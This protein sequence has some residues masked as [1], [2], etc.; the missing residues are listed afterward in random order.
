MCEF[1]EQCAKSR[2]SVALCLI[3]AVAGWLGCGGGAETSFVQRPTTPETPQPQP[4]TYTNPLLATIPSGGA[5]ESCADPSVLQAQDNNWYV[6]CTGDPLNDTD[7]NSTGGWIYHGIPIL[8][9][10][11]L[12]DWTYVGDVFATKPAWVAADGGLWAPLIRYSGGK[13]YL[14]YSASKTN[15]PGNGS[16]IGV[17]TSS[18]PAGPWTDAGA[19]VVEPGERAAIDPDVIED[20][21]EKYIYF[22]SFYGGIRVRKLS[23]DGLRSDASSEQ[24]IAISNR[25]EAANVVKRDGYYYLFA[26]ASDCCRGP[27]TG[28]SVFAGRSTSPQGPFLDRDGISLLAGRPGGTLALGMNGNRWV[29]PGHGA[30]FT[31]NARQDWMIYHAVDRNRPYFAGA[32][33]FTRRPLMLDPIDWVDGWPVVRGGN[34]ASDSSQAKPAAQAGETN[35]YS[36]TMRVNDAPGAVLTSDE[37]DAPAL[38]SLW[39]WVRPPAAA[40]YR[41]TGTA[42]QFDTQAAELHASTN[43]ASVLLQ[44]APAGDYMV[45][46]KVRFNVPADGCCQNFSQ[47]GLVIYGDDDNYVKL[48]HASIWET[49]QIEFGK[50]MSPVP[51]GYPVYGSSVLEA[52]DE[53]LYLRIVKHAKGSEELYTAYSS[54]DG[55]GWRAGGT[56]TH[57]LGANARIGLVSMGGAGFTGE[58]EYIRVY[59][60]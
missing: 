14:Y 56:W 55:I 16:A 35:P 28:Y 52:A 1:W 40:G 8:R 18:S 27:L 30:V 43:T 31:D 50:E 10:S 58:F 26:S 9:S 11:N 45:E 12:V 57:T 59:R 34:W 20:N 29:G 44:S 46:T 60:V 15:L 32:P 47:T 41:L 3:M 36:A 4:T 51:Q 17:A 49:R 33:G 53:Y 13:Y 39:S 48:V 25:Y 37:F 21:G 22:G 24:Q 54:R 38:A 42:L 2:R 19:P 7:K 23:A 6:Y 5:V